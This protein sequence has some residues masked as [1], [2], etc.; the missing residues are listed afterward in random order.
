MSD[1]ERGNWLAAIVV[2]C[3]MSVLHGCLITDSHQRLIARF[4]IATTAE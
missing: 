2:V 3:V 4:P 1:G